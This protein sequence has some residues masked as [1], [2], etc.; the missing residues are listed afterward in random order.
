MAK[1]SRRSRRRG[2]IKCSCEKVCFSEDG[3]A[4]ALL[5][6][7]IARSLYHSQKRKEIRAYFHYDC[8]HWHLTS[9]EERN[10]G[11]REL[12]EMR[13]EIASDS[14]KRGQYPPIL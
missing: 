10:S 8:G 6:A 13:D 14:D 3:A 12:S 1:S 4:N 7:K 11:E 5:N 2:G 9:K